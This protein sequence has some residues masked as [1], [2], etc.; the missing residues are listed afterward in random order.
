MILKSLGDFGSQRDVRRLI[1]A[2]PE[3]RNFANFGL[4]EQIIF[5]IVISAQPPGDSAAAS[6][7][8]EKC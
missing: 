2:R 8:V 1:F 6:A 4:H 7:N 5:H 3:V